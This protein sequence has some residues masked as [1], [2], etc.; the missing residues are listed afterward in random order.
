MHLIERYDAIAIGAE[1]AGM[2]LARKLANASRTTAL[3][4]REHL[5]GTCV[6]EDGTPTKTMIASARVAYLFLVSAGK[7]LGARATRSK[8]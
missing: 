4:Q 8:P 2:P 5:N 7:G 3:I 1:Q 6:N